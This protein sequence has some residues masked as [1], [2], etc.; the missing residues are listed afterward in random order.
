[1][2]EYNVNR[3]IW[4]RYEADGSEHQSDQQRTRKGP[5][6]GTDTHEGRD[7]GNQGEARGSEIVN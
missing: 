6:R 3:T 5:A 1:M 2:I 4:R 7:K